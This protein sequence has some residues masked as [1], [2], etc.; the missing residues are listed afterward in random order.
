MREITTQT[1]PMYRSETVEKATAAAVR[2]PLSFVFGKRPPDQTKT[3]EI[4]P[5]R[6]FQGK[7]P[8]SEPKTA[9]PL[10][11]PESPKSEISADPIEAEVLKRLKYETVTFKAAI[12][13]LHETIAERN[14]AIHEQKPPLLNC[15]S[16]SVSGSSGKSRKEIKIGYEGRLP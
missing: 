10:K 7:H 16:G 11:K 4:P 3:F 8:L 12:A 15:I 9:E 13:G 6:A 14:A 5:Y 1:M 2:K